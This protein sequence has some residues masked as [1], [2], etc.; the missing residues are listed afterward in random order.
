MHKVWK[1]EPLNPDPARAYTLD[2]GWYLNPVLFE[3]ERERIFARTWQVVA[4]ADQ[5]VKPGD[6]LATDAVGEPIVLVRDTQDQIRAYYNVC[7][8]RAGAVAR[9]QGSRK[10][11]QCLYHGWTFGLDGKLLRVPGFEGT[12]DF[13]PGCF[14]LKP[15]RVEQWGPYLFVNLDERAPALRNIWGDPFLRT[16]GIR[17]SDWRLVERSD[18]L[19]DCNWKVYMDNYAEGYHVPMAHPGLNR[20]MNLD[21]YQVDTYPYYSTQWVK[22]KPGTQGNLAKRRYT[23]PQPDDKICYHVVFPNFMID[24]YPDNI[25][26]NLLKPVAVDKTLLTFEWYF[27]DTVPDEARESMVKFADEIQ[28]EDIEICEYVQTN[29]K[30]RSY[31]AGRFSARHENGVHH[32]QGLVARFV[33]S[34]DPWADFSV[35][36]N[37]LAEARS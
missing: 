28:Y 6:Y 12:E 11:L 24:T 5:L 37:S 2:A 20:E 23:T 8:H 22:V 29:L 10:T 17:F 32:F 36:Q 13:D 7:P 19:I 3:I 14:G 30:S 25:S 31:H 34:D 27:S 9:G 15:V 1:N 4:R 26:V 18:Y 35:E 33:N 16:S 21:D